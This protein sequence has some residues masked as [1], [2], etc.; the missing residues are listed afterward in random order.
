MMSGNTNLKLYMFYVGG[1][2]R[3]SN[4]ELHDVRFSLGETPQDC[5]ADLQKQWWGTPSSLHI[6][7]WAEITHA[8]GFD[9]VLSDKAFEGSERLFFL[10]L[11]GYNADDFEEAHKNVLV[12]ANNQRTAIK[13]ALQAQKQWKQPHKDE[14]VNLENIVS[15]SKLGKKLGVFIHLLPVAKA[16]PLK[17]TAKYIRL[18]Q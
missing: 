10:N 12:V 3:N 16:K 9:V 2:F 1:S 5:Y 11:G 7:S 14:I 8:D 18:H 17:F 6:D 4:I 15:L 13:K